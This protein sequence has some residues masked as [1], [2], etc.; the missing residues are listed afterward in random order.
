M[1]SHFPPDCRSLNFCQT[2]H[3]YYGYG[4]SHVVLPRLKLGRWRRLCLRRCVCQTLYYKMTKTSINVEVIKTSP[5][6]D[7][8]P[9][10]SGLR[11]KVSVYEQQNYT[12]NFVQCIF[13]S[14]PEERRHGCTMIVGGD[15]RYYMAHTI[16]IIAKIAAANGVRNITWPFNVLALVLRNVTLCTISSRVLTVY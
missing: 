5:F 1:F 2:N 15:G 11:K 7:Q 12:E 8:K 13:D 16:Q 4:C 9:G 6:N 10:S 14:I 3:F